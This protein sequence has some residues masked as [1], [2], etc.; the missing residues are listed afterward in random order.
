MASSIG[1]RQRGAGRPFARGNKGGP[2]NPYTREVN[3]LRA[4]LYACVSEQDFGEVIAALVEGAK[5]GKLAFIRELL[6]RLIG[7]PIQGV[8]LTGQ[9]DEVPGD[10]SLG[11]IQ[12][13]VWD[14]LEGHTDLRVKLAQR[15][16]E[17]HERA[18]P[19]RVDQQA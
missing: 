4:K 9:A 13:A 3:L 12:L 17:L 10:V 2:G 15:L 16:R 18:Q 11:D 19:E 6:D 5:A 1:D 8:H 7:K 14:V